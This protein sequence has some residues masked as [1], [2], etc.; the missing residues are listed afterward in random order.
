MRGREDFVIPSLG[1]IDDGLPRYHE[2]H[3]EKEVVCLS[4]RNLK[5]RAEGAKSRADEIIKLKSAATRQCFY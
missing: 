4:M 2:V 1:E 3:R 5:D